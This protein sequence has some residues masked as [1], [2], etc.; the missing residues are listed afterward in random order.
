MESE[1]IGIVKQKHSPE[2]VFDWSMEDFYDWF[3][4]RS[5][6]S[7][8]P[9]NSNLFFLKSPTF[10]IGNVNFCLA[11]QIVPGDRE[12][13]V[14]LCNSGGPEVD[15]RY[16]SLSLVALDG[17]EEELISQINVRYK[18]D[19][20]VPD[21]IFDPLKL[22]QKFFP[23]GNLTIR[24]RVENEIKSEELLPNLPSLADNL[25]KLDSLQFSDAVLVFFYFKIKT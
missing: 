17:S 8:Q 16:M 2:T 7:P 15:M 12:C 3:D 19:E 20:T 22:D 9:D 14:W 4:V 25:G 10:S 18:E 11:F 6:L 5:D 24:C 23:N 13:R 1:K 21:T